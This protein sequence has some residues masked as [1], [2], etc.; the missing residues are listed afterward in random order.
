MLLLAT[1]SLRPLLE[2]EIWV[3]IGS[4]TDFPRSMLRNTGLDYVRKLLINAH[5]V[6]DKQIYMIWVDKVVVPT[7][8]S[9]FHLY[10]LDKV[11][12][13]SDIELRTMH[14]DTKYPGKTF[15]YWYVPCMV[16]EFGDI[17]WFFE[18]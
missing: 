1:S 5:L 4:S 2:V 13:V 18:E 16:H 8:G 17:T 14:F 12:D 10:P 9:T 11:E 3:S 6:A 7:S 15:G